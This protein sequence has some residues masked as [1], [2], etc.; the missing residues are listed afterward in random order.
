MIK[1]LSVQILWNVAFQTLKGRGG[2]H[3]NG[4]GGWR[5]GVPLGARRPAEFKAFATLKKDE[6]GKLHESANSVFRNGKPLEDSS[7]RSES[8]QREP[9]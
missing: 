4:T 9:T 6:E 1:R 2:C 8:T 5:W 3:G 7:E